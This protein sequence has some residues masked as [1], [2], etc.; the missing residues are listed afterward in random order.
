MGEKVGVWLSLEPKQ[1]KWLE[2]MTKKYGLPTAGTYYYR[3]VLLPLAHTTNTQ[4]KKYIHITKGQ[5]ISYCDT[6]H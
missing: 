2:T 3:V 1:V 5:G 4:Q 6:V